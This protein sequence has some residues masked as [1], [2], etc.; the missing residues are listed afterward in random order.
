MN[1]KT[2]L[3]ISAVIIFVF[4]LEAGA[5]GRNNNAANQNQK[6]NQDQN[7]LGQ[8]SNGNGTTTAS[9]TPSATA[10]QRRSQV[11]NAVQS[12]L[13]VADRQGGIGQQ[14]RVIAQNQ[15]Q[16][17]QRLENSLDKL[18]RRDFLAKFFIGPNYGEIKSIQEI[19]AQNRE[20]IIQL[21]QIMTQLSNQG[22]KT[23]LQEQ[24]KVLEQANLEI[25]N[26]LQNNQKGFSLFGWLF[27]IF[28][29]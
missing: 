11:A 1:K 15:N 6:Q 17:Q 18:Q 21:N 10:L 25:E 9:S 26:S 8:K 4:G 29:R 14:V 2:I 24:I 22:D 5:Q 13:Q 19:L 7:L 28:T 16:N 12:M 23:T 3:I 27:K 20:Q